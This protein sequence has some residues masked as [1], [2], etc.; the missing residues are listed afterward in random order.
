MLEKKK[1]EDYISEIAKKHNISKKATKTILVYAMKN[2]CRMI[3]RGED[4]NLNHFGN[5]YSNKK[6]FANYLKKAREKSKKD[7]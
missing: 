7:E 2:V 5:F 3:S 4:I 6:A 1:T